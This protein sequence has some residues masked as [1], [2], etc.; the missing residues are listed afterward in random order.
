MHFSEFSVVD[1]DN[2][3]RRTRK[4][5]MKTIL[6]FFALGFNY[7]VGLYYGIVNAF[8]TVLLTIALGVILRHVRRIKYEPFKEYSVSSQTPSISILIPAHNEDKVIVRT[9]TSALAVDYPIF[10]VI[11]IND[12][13]VDGTLE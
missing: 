2:I 8:Y 1:F 11:V 7:F 13:S 6:M 3:E 9:I 12:G 5:G 10:E 4:E